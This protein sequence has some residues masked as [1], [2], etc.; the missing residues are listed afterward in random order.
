MQGQTPAYLYLY[1]GPMGAQR[2]S[3]YQRMRTGDRYLLFGSSFLQIASDELITK[4]SFKMT[5]YCYSLILGLREIRRT[6]LIWR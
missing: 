1:L 2:R 3:C 6:L 5:S 4:L